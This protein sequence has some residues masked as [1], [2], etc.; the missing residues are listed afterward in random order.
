[1]R[2]F[3]RKHIPWFLFVCLVTAAAAALY[4]ANFYPE[5]VPEDRRLPP[6]FGETPPL[7]QTVG[8]TPLGLIFGAVSFAIF[9]FAA[10]LGLRKKIPLWRIGKVERWLRA[11]IWLT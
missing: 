1:M 10:L 4:V 7:H 3:N 8:G 2:I 5:W 11:H 9:I 6:F